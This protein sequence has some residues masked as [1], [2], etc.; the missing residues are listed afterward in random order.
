MSTDSDQRAGHRERLRARFLKSGLDGLADYEAVE[1]LLTL[2]IPRRDVKPL[3]KALLSR[4]GSLRS[5]LDAPATELQEVEGIGSTAVVAFRLV[6]ELA[7]LYQ[8]RSLEQR[9]VVSDPASLANLWRARLGNLRHEV[10]EVAY[11]DAGGRLLRDGIETIEEGSVTYAAVYPR[12]VIEG[13]LR[14]GAAAVVLA[15]NHPGGTPYPSEDDRAV[16]RRLADA[17]AAVEI[18]VVDHFI[19]ADDHV[20]SLRAHGLL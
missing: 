14:R 4:F 9:D 20:V 19:V 16:T 5:L 15:H 6:R 10:F 1:L 17:A 12:R 3:A 8:Q 18:S 13:A 11:L 2:A 7:G